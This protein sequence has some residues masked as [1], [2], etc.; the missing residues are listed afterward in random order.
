MVQCVSVL[1][2]TGSVGRQS[3]DIISRFPQIRV[4]ALT[5]GSNAQR[6]AE[7]CRQFSPA[8]AVMSTEAAAR[9]LEALIPDRTVK[10]VKTEESCL[11]GA[12]LAAFA[13]PM[14]AL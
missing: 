3:L 10:I 11:R 7:Q 9:E 5:A 12:A 8:L 14:E 6:M 13:E 4:A 1:G 2:S